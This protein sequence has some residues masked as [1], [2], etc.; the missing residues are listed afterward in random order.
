MPTIV[1]VAAP[2][3]GAALLEAT[4][5]Y[6]LREENLTSEYMKMV[7]SPSYWIITGIFTILAPIAILIFFGDQTAPELLL[8]GAAAPTII[9]KLIS[10][11]GEKSKL[12]LGVDDEP[13]AP[14]MG[15]FR[16]GG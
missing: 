7:K 14:V 13:K 1:Q 4:H 16:T 5:W 10:A 6:Q 12:T 9:K 8:Y 11:A 2:F 3:V 15:Y